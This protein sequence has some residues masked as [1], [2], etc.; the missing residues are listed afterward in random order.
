[1]KYEED[2]NRH[3]CKEDS[4]MAK[5]HMKWCSTSLNIREIPIKTLMSSHLTLV[6]MV[7]INNPRHNR[8]WWG[9]RE[10]GSVLYWWW[11]CNLVQPLWKTVWRCLKK[12]KIERPYDPAITLLVSYPSKQQRPSL[13]PPLSW[14]QR[15]AAL[16]RSGAMEQ[17]VH[18]GLGCVTGW[19]LDECV[20]GHGAGVLC[21]RSEWVGV[22]AL[23]CPLGHSQVPWWPQFWLVLWIPQVST[24]S[25]GLLPS[26]RRP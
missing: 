4:Q 21:R 14:K 22:W 19:G 26:Q 2:M 13:H 17:E 15:M 3:F 11:E 1:M 24:Q 10:R 6:R 18:K 20:P 12:L 16:L 25:Q 23:P 8:C 7:N 9:F 5:R